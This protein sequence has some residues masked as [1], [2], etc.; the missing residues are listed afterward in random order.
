VPL[1]IINEITD[2]QTIATGASIR[3]FPACVEYM[4]RDDGG[5]ERG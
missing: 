2:V 4:V 5:K 3:D 1:E